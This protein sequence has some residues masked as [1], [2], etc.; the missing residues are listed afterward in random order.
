MV[1]PMSYVD[2]N[3]DK[4]DILPKKGMIKALLL[5]W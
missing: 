4:L 1:V 3:K 2:Q 5:D